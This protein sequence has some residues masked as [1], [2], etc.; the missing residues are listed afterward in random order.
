LRIALVGCGFVADYYMATL[1]SYPG[2][3]VVG[4]FDVCPVALKR[5]TAYHQVCPYPSI[6][7]LL[8]DHRIEMVVNLT[9]P[10]SHFEVSAKALHAGKHVYS[11]KPLAMTMNEAKALV[12][13]ARER[14]CSLS[15]APCSILSETAKTVWHSLKDGKIGQPRLVYAEID[16][17]MVHKMP[18]RL[19]QSRSG[20]NWPY[21]DEFE[22]GCTLQHAGYYLTWLTFFF[23]P[24]KSVTAFSSCLIVDKETNQP[25]SPAETPDFSTAVLNFA[26]G[27][28]ARITCGIVA[29]HDHSLKIIGDSGNLHVDDSW[30]YRSPVYIK[31]RVRL[32]R[33]VFIS[34]LKE[35]C[36]LPRISKKSRFDYGGAQQMDFARGIHSLAL[37]V[38]QGVRGHMPEDFCLHNAEIYLCIHNATA[39]GK[40]AA[41][42]TTFAHLE[43]FD[44][45]YL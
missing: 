7:A 25:L 13:L 27:M 43:P 45:K 9:N 36:P 35:R 31:R 42:E 16:D 11:E 19:W 15:A 22:V 29:P 37:A 2:L 24:V 30:D 5:F 23:G 20:A 18:Y 10:R 33:R 38:Q 4:V 32:R 14:G 17:G 8:S 39:A 6:D 12:S 21:K 34:P 40:T 41:M 1:K 44:W 3:E 26:S 28:V